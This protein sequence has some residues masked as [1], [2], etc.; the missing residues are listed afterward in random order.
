MILHKKHAQENDFSLWPT[1]PLVAG[2]AIGPSV[3]GRKIPLQRVWES[4]R[5]QGLREK[6]PRLI[7]PK[8][9]LQSSEFKALDPLSFST[10]D[11]LGELKICWWKY[12]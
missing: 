12:S 8:E 2:L 10:R 1:T 6:F 3:G 11:L 4:M 9:P 5:L 7:L